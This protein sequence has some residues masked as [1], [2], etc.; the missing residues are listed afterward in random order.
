L[1]LHQW[2]HSLTCPLMAVQ[3]APLRPPLVGCMLQRQACLSSRPLSCFSSCGGAG[4]DGRVSWHGGAGPTPG[5][6]ADDH[7]SATAG[8]FGTRRRQRAG[9]HL[10]PAPA[11]G[12]ASA[13]AHPSSVHGAGVYAL[14]IFVTLASLATGLQV[15][16]EMRGS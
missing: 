11:Q 9:P 5:P 13:C 14:A 15:R 10:P 16:R 8:D 2:L 3:R 12:L 4:G 6:A 7:V 1:I